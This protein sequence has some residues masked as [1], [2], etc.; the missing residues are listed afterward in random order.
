MVEIQLSK[1][2]ELTFKLQIEGSNETPVGKLSIQLK[3]GELFFPGRIEEDYVIVRIPSLSTFREALPGNSLQ[4]SL[5]VYVDGQ[6]FTP[7]EDSVN[8]TNPISVKA[9]AVSSTSNRIV[10]TPAKPKVQVTTRII[11]EDTAP[12][13]PEIKEFFKDLSKR[14]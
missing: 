11:E 4:A 8:V 3:E 6:H 5:H 10:E 1:P 2:A 9:E 13:R 12:R 7:W 14:K